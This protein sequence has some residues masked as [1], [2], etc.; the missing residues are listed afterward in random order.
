[1]KI[2]KHAWLPALF[3]VFSWGACA[4]EPA[5][6]ASAILQKIT[7]D[8]TGPVWPVIN[9]ITK[10]K[11]EKDE[12][13]AAFTQKLLEL[14][15]PEAESVDLSNAAQV[16]LGGTLLSLGE[17][18]EGTLVTERVIRNPQAPLGRRIE[19]A[20]QL[21]FCGGEYSGAHLRQLLKDAKE[22]NAAAVF[23]PVLQVELVKSLWELT[24]TPEAKEQLKDFAF[25]CPDRQAATAAVLALGRIGQYD[26]PKADDPLRVA[27]RD[28]SQTPGDA[29]AEAKILMRLDS[30]RAKAVTSDKFTSDLLAEIVEKIRTRYAFDQ[31]NETEAEQ[32]TPEKLASNAARALV[33]SLDDFS[34]YLDAEDYQEM[35]NSMHGDYGGIGA[36]VG[37]RNGIFTV[38]APMWNKPAHK[39]GLRTMDIVTKVEGE[40][41]NKLPLDKIIKRLKGKPGTKVRMTVIRK[42]VDEPF[43][44]IV[45][46][47]IINMPMMHFQMLPGKIGYIRLTGFQEDPERRVSTSSELKRALLALKKD[48]VKGIILDLRNNPGGLL[49][50]AVLVCENFIKRNELIVYSKGTFQPRRNYVSKIIGEPTYTGPLAVLI[51]GGSASA[52]EI[53]SGALRDHKRA[54]L[55]GEKSFGKGSVQMLLPVET[56]ENSRLKLTIARYYLPSGE[57]I[58]GRDKGIKPHVTIEEPKFTEIERELRLKEMENRDIYVWLEENFDKNKDA[59]LG[60]LEYDGKDCEKYPGFDS[61]YEQLCQKYPK[62]K[63]DKDTVRR[64]LRS[65]LFAFMFESRG[66]DGNTVDLMESEALKRAIVVLGEK[67][68]GLPDIPVYNEFKDKWKEEDAKLAAEAQK[69]AD[70]AAGKIDNAKAGE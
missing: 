45:N 52:S 58:H 46:R 44:V 63:L 67:I 23:P 20:A 38:L 9:D 68:G 43:D 41:I 33:R 1:M 29:G 6:E 50:E 31:N 11:P 7:D 62:L 32:T 42:G 34:D 3:V 17:Q 55:V 54:T 14:A 36:Y 35:L 19:A 65:N 47:E 10:L 28:L 5:A 8:A 61:L 22:P 53:V 30:R 56:A 64:E 40:E 60:L 51:N 21:G 24:F 13:G 48:G 4:A 39:A 26:T 49:S 70:E 2:M 59:F 69:K 37:L 16:A 27:L 18:K 25:T 57:C 12:D 15:R 66:I